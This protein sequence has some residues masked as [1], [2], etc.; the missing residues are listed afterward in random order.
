MLTLADII[1]HYRE[2][3]SPSEFPIALWT[4]LHLA[5]LAWESGATVRKMGGRGRRKLTIKS[6]DCEV[7]RCHSSLMWSSAYF[8]IVR[9][10]I[11]LSTTWGRDTSM[12]SVLREGLSGGNEQWREGRPEGKSSSLGATCRWCN[13]WQGVSESQERGWSKLSLSSCSFLLTV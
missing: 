9:L 3:A 4:W 5:H 6:G 7:R 10:C 12:C 1:L 13:R 8:R 2:S 11:N